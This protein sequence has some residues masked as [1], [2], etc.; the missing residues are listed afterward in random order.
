M[1]YLYMKY[2]LTGLFSYPRGLLVS[3]PGRGVS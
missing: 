1:V 2:L 3:P